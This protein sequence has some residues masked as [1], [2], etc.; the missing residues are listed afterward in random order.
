MVDIFVKK[1]K[2]KLIYC[3]CSECRLVQENLALDFISSLSVV[4]PLGLVSLGLRYPQ[5]GGGTGQL[6]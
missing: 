5:I 2:K 6:G 3:V 1:K 4:A